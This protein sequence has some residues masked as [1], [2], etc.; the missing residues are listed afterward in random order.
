MKTKLRANR[1]ELRGLE[2]FGTV[3]TRFGGED[4]WLHFTMSHTPSYIEEYQESLEEL[5]TYHDAYM[6]AYGLEAENLV[7]PTVK[8]D[9]NGLIEER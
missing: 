2:R 7:N 9:R 8:Y 4:E 6:L 5:E 3:S 1:Y